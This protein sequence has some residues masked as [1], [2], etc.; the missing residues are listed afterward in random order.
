MCLECG[1][2]RVPGVEGPKDLD[3]FP[4]GSGATSEADIRH[5][6]FE[7]RMDRCITARLTAEKAGILSGIHRAR[8]QM[9]A[10]GLSFA[11]SLEDGASVE[12][13]D[14]IAR[15]MGDPF[16]VAKAEERIIGTLSKSSGIATAAR[17][18]SLCVGPTCRVVS[19]GWK[20]MPLEMKEIL[21]QAVRDGGV[22]TRI[23]EGHFFYLDKNYVRILGGIAEAVQAALSL[24]R[25][26]VIQVRGEFGPVEE[27]A[28][29]AARLGAEV[30]MV[31]TGRPGDLKE[32]IAA[33]ERERLRSRVKV[34]FAGN[35]SL[36]GLE[37]LAK[38]G[39][40]LLDVG[41][42][43]LDAPCLPMRFDVV[44][45][46]ESNLGDMDGFPREAPMAAE[47]KAP[48]EFRLLEK[49]E[50]WISPLALNEVDLGLCA[51][52]AA[53]VLGLEPEEVMV[54]DVLE[55]RITLDLLI[56]TI[57]A[58]QIVGRGQ[59]LLQAM[60]ELPGVCVTDRTEVHS[61]GVLGLIG[62]DEAEGRRIVERSRSMGAQ[63]L[64]RIRKRAMVFSSGQELLQ[65]RIQDTN[66]PFLM[67]VLRSEGYRA[68]RGPILE[69]DAV[70]I[71][72]ALQRAAEDGYG[73]VVTTGGI[74]AEGKDQT[75]EA[76]MRIDPHA[77]TPYILRFREGQG[78]H[79]KDG[80]RIGVGAAF[81]TLIVCLPGPH[82]EVRLAWRPLSEGLRGGQ[83]KAA[84]AEAIARV[85]RQKFL[86]RSVHGSA[87]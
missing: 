28:V 3:L 22:A 64:A 84:L 58:E 20:K 57:R 52:T 34:A 86:A 15:V 85:L 70:S 9:E 31:D 60:G 7:G 81:Q 53:E 68:A 42:A 45:V 35:V 10:L 56:P 77:Q 36:G 6:I 73:L 5:Q 12:A 76:L 87:R 74:G 67:E 19:G 26:A 13:G 25:D 47:E 39:A 44:E 49:T 61:S 82:D 32:V 62:M 14:E 21:R 83:D 55:D 33:L 66:A 65:G 4:K 79:A 51:R 16:Q 63:I 71:Y 69:D 24:G 59:A 40:D 75:L 50:L 38:M 41:Y 23:H 27:E 43:I 1:V 18:A 80:V 48:L 29:N 30:V 17:Q 2:P 11:S 78:R 72:R 8:Q 54:T 46:R 37:R